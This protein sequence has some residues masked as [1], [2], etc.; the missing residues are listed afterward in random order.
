MFDSL[1]ATA[2]GC[3]APPTPVF[4]ECSE[5]LAQCDPITG[6]LSAQRFRTNAQLRD[7]TQVSMTQPESR[8]RKDIDILFVIDNAAQMAKKKKKKKCTARCHFAISP[9]Q[10]R[11]T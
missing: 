3:V 10:K 9:S 2:L 5:Y 1:G 6:G 8:L 7:S 4:V 11:R